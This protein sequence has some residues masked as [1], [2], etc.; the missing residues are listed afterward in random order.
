MMEQEQK[1]ELATVL[2][3]W[4]AELLQMAANH[5]EQFSRMCR[6]DDAVEKIRRVH[7]ERFRND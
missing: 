4:A 5:P 2:P 3:R 6:I 1:K 7:P